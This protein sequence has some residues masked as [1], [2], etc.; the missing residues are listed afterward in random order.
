MKD[1]PIECPYLQMT[2]QTSGDTH[3]SHASRDSDARSRYLVWCQI[4][5][6]LCS[7][8]SARKQS[9]NVHFIV[10]ILDYIWFFIN[11]TWRA[12]DLVKSP[13]LLSPCRDFPARM[14]S[15]QLSCSLQ[16]SSVFLNSPRSSSLLARL[17][18]PHHCVPETKQLHCSHY[19]LLPSSAL[20]IEAVCSSETLSTSLQGFTTVETNFDIFT[21]VW[22]LNLLCL[23]MDR[24]RFFFSFLISK[25]SYHSTLHN[26]GSWKYSSNNEYDR[27]SMAMPCI[28][29]SLRHPANHVIKIFM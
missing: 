27:L 16:Q 24:H 8:G 23:K 6:S 28:F 5:Q 11:K 1:R 9:C 15:G 2:T 19:T 13:E 26:L 3:N 22:V 4:A 17:P 12:A 18:S 7:A 25:S 21:A 14:L 29:F 20:M 10:R